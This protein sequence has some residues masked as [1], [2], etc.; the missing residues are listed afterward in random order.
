[1]NFLL[2]IN[3]YFYLCTL[4]HFT[5]F[6][7]VWIFLKIVASLKIRKHASVDPL[8]EI[9]VYPTFKVAIKLKEKS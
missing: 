5:L 4:Y 1:M 7:I 2:K 8:F 3:L 6:H 9:I